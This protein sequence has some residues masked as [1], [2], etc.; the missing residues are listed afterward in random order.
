MGI[1]DGIEKAEITKRGVYL[2]PGHEYTLRIKKCDLI[3][4]RDKGDAYVVDFEVVES[5]CDKDPPGQERNWYQSTRD[6]NVFLGAVKGFL[7][8][9]YGYDLSTMEDRFDRELAP[10]LAAIAHGSQVEH[11]NTLAGQ[12]VK[13]RT[14]QIITEKKKQEFTRH[15]WFPYQVRP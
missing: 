10:A 3:E 6:K 8:A 15:D 14:K 11:G 13:V 5:T 7:A 4:T 12:L 1:W 2:Q 9:V